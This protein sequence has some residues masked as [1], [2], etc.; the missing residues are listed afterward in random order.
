LLARVQSLSAASDFARLAQDEGLRATLA[1]LGAAFLGQVSSLPRQADPVARF[2]LHNGARL[3]RI[4]HQADLSVKGLKQSLGLMVNYLYD[5][6]AI[7]EN[8]DAFLRG[9]IVRSKS[10]ADLISR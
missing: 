7:E 10:V 3:E 9:D 6:P 4:N 8:H 1:S 5:L 2:H